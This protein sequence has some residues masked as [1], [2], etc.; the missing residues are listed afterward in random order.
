MSRI[1]RERSLTSI[2]RLLAGLLVLTAAL[3]VAAATPDMLPPPEGDIPA[4]FNQP[5][6]ADDYVEREAMISMRD[7]VR[8]YT[9]IVIP[10]VGRMM[11]RSC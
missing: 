11:R 1:R 8:L 4:H 9:V 10:K 5:T 6:A 3:A 2:V 7:G